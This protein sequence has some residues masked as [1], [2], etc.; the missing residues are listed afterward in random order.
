MP[1]HINA[2]IPE[3]KEED[4]LEWIIGEALSQAKVKY[5]SQDEHFLLLEK[6][7]VDIGSQ[8][9]IAKLVYTMVKDEENKRMQLIDI[10]IV[11]KNDFTT[12]LELLEKLPASSDANE[13]YDAEVV[14]KGGHLQ[15]ETVNRHTYK[16]ELEGKNHKFYLSVFPFYVEVRKNIDEINE[17]FNFSENIKV[18]D[19]EAKVGGFAEDFM[20]PA[21]LFKVF[22]G[23]VADDETFT[24]LFG[25]VEE[26]KEVSIETF[27]EDENI[28][29]LIVTVKSGMGNVPVAMSR[30]AFELEDIHVGRMLIL[31]A[32]I[33]ADLCEF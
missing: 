3:A 13:Y 28:D 30:E 29:F 12:E 5:V 31:K 16:E 2:I 15:I 27:E 4:L 32:D 11:L 10:D 7:I 18:G 9:I 26:I 21:S 24:Y 6:G 1:L 25:E 14:N 8:E 33:K 17:L 19:S 20:A 23:H 22:D